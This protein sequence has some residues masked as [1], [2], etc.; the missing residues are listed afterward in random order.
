MGIMRAAL[1]IFLFLTTAVVA[2]N[3]PTG[4]RV[5][6]SEFSAKVAPKHTIRMVL[7]DGTLVEGHPLQLTADAMELSITR[8]SNRQAH[9]KGRATIPRGSV[10]VVEV[11]SPRW[12]GKLIGALA[13][14]GIGTAIAVGGM[15]ANQGSDDIYVYAA[16]GGLTIAAGAPAGLLVGRAIDRRFE[17]FTIIPAALKE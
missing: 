14:I 16:A 11:R 15:A 12:K 3:I 9:A 5:T 7:P 10:S 17:R 6:W 1:S 4:N 2:G 13:P 8:T